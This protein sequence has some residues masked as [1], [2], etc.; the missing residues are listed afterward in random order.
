MKGNNLLEKYMSAVQK[1][2]VL[3]VSYADPTIPAVMSAICAEVFSYT[4][5]R[6]NKPSRFCQ[7]GLNGCAMQTIIQS[8]LLMEAHS[9]FPL[10]YLLSGPAPKS[11]SHLLTTVGA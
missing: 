9:L 5:Q 6:L 3:D 7:S 1:M 2:T 10:E 4:W 11:Q 8:N